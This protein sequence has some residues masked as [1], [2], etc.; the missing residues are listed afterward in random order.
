MRHYALCSTYRAYVPL[1]RKFI[2]PLHQLNERHATKFA[3][4]PWG[5]PSFNRLPPDERKD[6]NVLQLNFPNKAKNLYTTDPEMRRLL[7]SSLRWV[8]DTKLL[9]LEPLEREA[10]NYAW[11]KIKEHLYV[12]LR[13][14]DLE[15]QVKDYDISIANFIRPSDPKSLLAQLSNRNKISNE[16]WEAILNTQ[17]VSEEQKCKYIVGGIY[18]HIF[19]QE[20]LPLVAP[21]RS[22]T[23]SAEDVDISNPAEWF[24]EARKW[25]RRIIM[26][27]GSTNS[28]KTY[29]ALQR[30]KQCDRGYY[31]GPLRLLAREVYERFKGENIRCNLLTGEEVIE[32]LDEMGNPAGITSGTVEMVPL[33]QKFDVVV[34]DEIQ[35]MGDSD[36]GWAWT[37][38]LMGAIAREVHLCGEKSALPLVEKIVKMTGDELIV[39]EYERLGE[40]KIE[41]T[42]LK[43]GLKGLRKGDCVVAFSKKKILDL[44]LKIEKMTDLKV[45]V[46]YGSLPPETR[47][48]QANMFNKGDYDVLVASDAVGMGLNLSIERVIFTTHMKFNGQEMVGLTSSNVKQIGGRAGRYKVANVSTSG[49][50]EGK[51]ASVGYVTGVDSDVLAAIKDGMTAPV[52]YLKSAIV[53]PTDEICGKLMTH[54]PPGARVSTLL[55]TLAKEVEK[56]SAKVF[57]L[58]ELKNRLTNIEMFEHMDGIPFFDKMRLSNAP[59]KDFPL[60]KKAYIQF[61]TTIEQRQT[62]SLFSYPFSFD[63]LD[64]KYIN[65]DKYSL[66]HYESLHNII[67]LYFWLSNR[68]PNYFI[69]QQSAR[70]LKDICEMIIFEKLDRLKKNPY[71]RKGPPGGLRGIP[72]PSFVKHN[73]AV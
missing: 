22:S 14:K 71:I 8:F 29:Q 54:L 53:W 17:Q 7:D 59:V 39:N 48:Q 73:R 42:S 9:A 24:P 60:V 30:L 70:Q 1:Y 51:K 58:S 34:L 33:S 49:P 65:S 6:L 4:W 15:Q 32:E 27:I 12:Q 40:L 64:P 72:R 50:D 63:I 47:I 62:R 20:I 19:Q 52:E 61:C 45:A 38:A 26:H 3:E 10:K 11:L 28:G 16:S 5:K 31:A 2:R 69:D 41:D 13:D 55:L 25:R 37:N 35:M 43:G 23:N 57:T 67:M 36:R 68:Y 46:I 18:D 44:K 66:E 56:R 21:I